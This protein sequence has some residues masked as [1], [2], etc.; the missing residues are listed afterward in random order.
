MVLKIQRGVFHNNSNAREA[1]I[2]EGDLRC[3][4]ARVFGCV[5]CDWGGEQVSV[6]VM[7]RLLW[8]F[9]AYASFW[10]G[11]HPGPETIHPLL[12]SIGSFFSVLRILAVD[13]RYCVRDC[14]WG[15]VGVSYD[16]VVVMLD[17][18]AFVHDPLNN[19]KRAD[20]CNKEGNHL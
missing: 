16:H 10:F 1:A 18:E 19:A 4:T 12:L 9:D 6:L 11:C 2:A 7:E 17:F 3:C 15:N 8:D 20:K 5:K 13:L 14:H